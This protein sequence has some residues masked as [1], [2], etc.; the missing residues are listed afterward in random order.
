MHSSL[1]K[2]SKVAQK[3]TLIGMFLDLG[4]GFLKLVIGGIANSHALLADGIH[5]LSDAVTDIFVL[6]VTRISSHA[7][8]ANHPYGHAR[9]ETL[10]TMLLGSSLIAIAVILAY[11]YFSLLVTAR[12]DSLPT[13]PALAVAL[14]SIVCKEWIFRYTRR[15]GEQLRSN[16]LI[17]NAWHSRSD[18]LSSIIVF[19]GIA[20]SMLGLPWLDIVAALAV[21][22]IIGKIGARLVWATLKELVDTG[23]DETELTAIRETLLSIAG[24]NGVHDLR[25]RRMGQSILLEMHLQVGPGI[26][27][28]EGH[29][30]GE[31]AAREL[32]NQFVSIND[33]TFHIDA[34]DDHSAHLRAN[35]NLLPLRQEVIESLNN[36]WPA[37]LEIDHITLHY[38][39]NRIDI[40]LYLSQ[41]DTTAITPAEIKQQ[42]DLQQHLPWLGKVSV[43]CETGEKDERC[44]MQD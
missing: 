37:S 29:N 6:F 35:D 42:L 34:E 21:A 25:T 14:L 12:D 7:P 23:L 13:W 4:L 9:F 2:R 20:A 24:I 38:L 31:W 16:L 43:W 17:A 44:E 28:S 32:L 10:A 41:C 33:V 1:A 27:V 22:F 11:N 40:E 36:C 19:I 3:V 30:I 8:D 5:S 26:S 39:N 15:A 18:A